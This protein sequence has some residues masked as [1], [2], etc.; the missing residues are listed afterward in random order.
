MAHGMHLNETGKIWIGVHK[1]VWYIIV[2]SGQQDLSVPLAIAMEGFRPCKGIPA[3]SLRQ[4]HLT[5]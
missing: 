3:G 4:G 1:A 5:G 2:S